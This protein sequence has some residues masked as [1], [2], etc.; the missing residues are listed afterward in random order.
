MTARLWWILWKDLVSECRS[1]RVW[2]AMLL[3]G[4]VVGFTFAGQMDLPAEQQQRVAGGLVWLAIFLA[5]MPAVERSFAAEREDGC[6]EGL[7]LYPISPGGIYLAKLAVN[8]V[9]LAVLEGVLIPLFVVLSGV[10]LLAHP[11]ATLLVA[12]LGNLAL[13]A[14]GTLLGALA[15]GSRHS[16][17]LVPLLVLPMAVPAVLAAA[18][19]TRLA[20]DGEFGEPWWHWIQVLAAFAVLFTTIGIALFDF[21]IEE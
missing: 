19:A 18:E 12:V 9:A 4:I 14:A 15:A 2:P 20:M 16:P 5:G 17:Y 7:R 11:G 10:P 3:L 8:V 21:V 13:A 6:W 1:R